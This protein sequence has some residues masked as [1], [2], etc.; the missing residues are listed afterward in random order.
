M[1]CRKVCKQGREDM[2]VKASPTPRSF[3]YQHCTFPFM[4]KMIHTHRNEI[5]I[6]L[7]IQHKHIWAQ[8]L[9]IDT[10]MVR[11]FPTVYKHV[12]LALGSDHTA[13][14]KVEMSRGRGQSVCSCRVSHKNFLKL[15]FSE[16]C[17]ARCKFIFD[18][19]WKVLVWLTSSCEAMLQSLISL[20]AQSRQISK[21][22]RTYVD[23]SHCYC[24]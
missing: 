6:L 1:T 13:R 10:N 11:V 5:I 22:V 14:I 23:G 15:T 12:L 2:K 21:Y 19:G 4:G 8:A 20:I 24:T 3:S 18:V 16:C 7:F 17:M 9:W